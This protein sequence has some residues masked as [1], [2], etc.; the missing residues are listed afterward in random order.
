[1][2]KMKTIWIINQD[3]STPDTGYAGRSYYLAEELGKL[4]HKV[5][6]IAGGYS[7]LHFRRPTI[8][9]DIEIVKNNNF[10]FVWINLPSYDNAHSKKRIL[11]W[12]IFAYRLPKLIK[13]IPQKPNVL[14]YSSPPLIGFLGTVVFF[15]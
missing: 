15:F 10:D 1:M 6:L 3:A 2:F 4:G 7:H 12:F 14:I 9:N 5:Y 11:N 8:N 13:I